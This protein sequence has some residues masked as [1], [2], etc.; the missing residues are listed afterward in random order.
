MWSTS[1]APPLSA[2]G[3]ARAHTVEHVLAALYAGGIDNARLD[4][5]GPEPPIADGSSAPYV[6]L[7]RQA[8]IVE[9]ALP[10]RYLR[11]RRPQFIEQ[12]GSKLVIVPDDAYRVSCTV[13][14]GVSLLDTQY[15]SLAVT[16]D[17]FAA[18]LSQARTFCL[19]EEIA[20]LM[21]RNLIRGGSLDNAVV[22]KDGAILSSN[23]LRYPD[24]FVRH[25]MLDIVGDLSL[26]GR[27]LLGQVIAVKPGHPLNVTMAQHLRR[28][29]LAA[30]APAA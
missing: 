25:K 4:M 15:L 19:Y 1:C 5:D 9:Q 3:D 17:S 14:Y 23:G 8:G 7:L 13:K 16:A 26:V 28:L 21:S 29:A 27:R 2:S 30:G 18:E 20:A 22:L 11:I 12:G 10:R 6:T 24:E